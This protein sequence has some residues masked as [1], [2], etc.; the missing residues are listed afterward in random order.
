MTSG[1][2]A[3]GFTILSGDWSMAMSTSLASSYPDPTIDG[4]FRV[5][6]AASSNLPATPPQIGNNFLLPH[7]SVSIDGFSAPPNPV[8][9]PTTLVLVTIGLVGFG[10]ARKR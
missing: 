1:Y 8:P 5:L 6:G 9:E 10:F 7:F 4:N 2:Y 3:L